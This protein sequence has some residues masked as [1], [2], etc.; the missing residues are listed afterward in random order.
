[1]LPYLKCD[2]S[3]TC[4]NVHQSVNRLVHSEFQ[5]LRQIEEDLNFLGKWKTT[6]KFLWMEDKLNFEE[7][8]GDL[9]FYRQM[10]DDLNFVMQMEDEPQF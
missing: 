10:E 8:K 3:S 1:M 6:S 2:S 7:T 9:N 4:D 5:S